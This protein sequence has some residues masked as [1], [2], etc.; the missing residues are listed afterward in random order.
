MPFKI[1]GTAEF[2][3]FDKLQNTVVC[4]RTTWLVRRVGAMVRSEER[5]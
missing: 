5:V 4:G 1:S 2:M 3:L